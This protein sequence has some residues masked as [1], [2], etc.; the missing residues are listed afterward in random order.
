MH[1]LV[2][3][4]AKSPI[5]QPSPR[6]FFFHETKQE[7]ALKSHTFHPV[8]LS[9]IHYI[10][11]AERAKA[12]TDMGPALISWTWRTQAREADVMWPSCRSADKTGQKQ[13]TQYCGLPPRKLFCCPHLFWYVCRKI[14]LSIKTL[15]RQL[16]VC[17][18]ARVCPV[19]RCNY[20]CVQ[21]R[22]PKCSAC[23]SPTL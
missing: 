14:N 9:N 23:Y 17:V 3:N 21:Q 10:P 7:V 13:T 6:R 11:T 4:S 15:Q 1:N 5:F 18:C 20:M 8:N 19:A 22:G 16:C 2:P 12:P